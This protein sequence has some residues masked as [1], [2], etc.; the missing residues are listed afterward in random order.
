MRPRQFILRDGAFAPPQDEVCQARGHACA[1]P[2]LKKRFV[3][4][5]RHR[6][7]GEVPMAKKK[8]TSRAAAKTAVRK[9]WTGLQSAAKP[10]AR[11]TIKSKGRVSATKSKAVKSKA[12]P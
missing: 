7:T 4:A 12:R 6:T 9:K 8:A 5:S 1:L 10:S 3:L 2:T 11:K